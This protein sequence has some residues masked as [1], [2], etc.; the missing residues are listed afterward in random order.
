MDAGLPFEDREPGLGSRVGR[1]L[2]IA[3]CRPGSG[4]PALARSRSLGAPWRFKLL[5]ALPHYLSAAMLLG[6]L[7]LVLAAA[8]RAHPDPLP[9]GTSLYLP[10]LLLAL[11]VLGPVLQGLTM[12]VGGMVLH[13]LLWAL[14]GTRERVGLRQTLRA[15]GYTQAVTGLLWVAPP[16]AA[17]AY[18]ISKVVLGQG[19]ARIH[20]TAR[21]K[22]LAAALIQGLLATLTALALLA[23]LVFW[24]VR[25]DQRARQIALPVPELEPLPAQHPDLI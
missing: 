9:A 18:P 7:Q 24:L 21:W 22:G 10:G 3:L 20:R 6:L 16:L 5:L 11:V 23:G 12:V 15:I 2:K 25:L 19:L 13:A 14:G 17:V 8:A 1:T 4:Y